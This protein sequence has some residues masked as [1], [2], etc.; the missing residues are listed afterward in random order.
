MIK[1]AALLFVLLFSSPAHAFLF[2][3]NGGYNRGARTVANGLMWSGRTLTFYVNTNQRIMGGSVVPELDTTEFQ[4]AITLAVAAWN[5]TCG[6]NLRVVVGGTTNNVMASGDL[7]NTI[8]WD[9]RTTAEGSYRQDTDV[10]AFASP[11]VS[12]DT[13][14]DC[15][16]VVNG[17]S[18][19]TFTNDGSGHDLRSILI[20]EIG[21]CLGLDHTA[22]PPDYTSSN[23][24]LLN[25]VM[26]AGLSAADVSKR[27]LSQDELDF[28]ECIYPNTNGFAARG[29]FFCTSYHG[30]TNGAAVSGTL[31]GGPA[32]TRTCGDGQSAAVTKSTSS[33]GG[34]MA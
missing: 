24:I 14:I 8:M 23:S 6:T 9:D 34:C 16:V 13:V 1:V 29:G 18:S 3:N 31:S 7:V 27:A 19:G 5:N 28:A 11:N 30:S 22:E 26:F 12:G 32:S 17:E 2:I 25:S 21:H 20:H 33:G 10:L 15:D 4:S